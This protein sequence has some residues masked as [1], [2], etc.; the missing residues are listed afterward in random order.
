MEICKIDGCKNEHHARGYCK[1]C[2][3]KLR[4]T[5]G[6]KETAKSPKSVSSRADKGRK[7]GKSASHSA[8]EVEVTKPAKAAKPPA[9]RLELIRQRLSVLEIEKAKI[10]ESFDDEGDE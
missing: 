9:N 1:K 2:Y 6:L 10:A 4:R 5:G 3:S 8:P 7:R